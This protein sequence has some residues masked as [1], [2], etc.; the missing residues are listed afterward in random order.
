MFGERIE[1]PGFS[2]TITVWRARQSC[3][4]TAT[5]ITAS[6]FPDV[7]YIRWHV[8]EMQHVLPDDAKMDLLAG[9]HLYRHRPGIWNDVSVDQFGE[10]TYTKKGKMPGGFE[11]ISHVRRPSGHLGGVL[12]HLCPCHTRHRVH[13]IS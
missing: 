11:G 10:Q 3:R 4:M 8:M 13:E 5:C 7:R 6:S 12:P 2:N 9:A 1:A